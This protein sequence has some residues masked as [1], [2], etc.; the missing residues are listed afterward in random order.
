M[1][2]L[3]EPQTR[4]S[5]LSSQIPAAAPPTVARARWLDAMRGFTMIC[6]IS[7]GFGFPRLAGEAW[8][9]PIARQF[10]HV[11]WSG[12]TAWDLVQPFFM[13]IVGAAMPFAFA[14]RRAR[15][16]TWSNGWAHVLWRAFM[17]L[18][19]SQIAMIG[20]GST[21]GVQL[22]N[23]LAQIAFTYVIAYC[24]LDLPW[25]AQLLVAFGLLLAHYLMH[26]FWSGV[27]AGGMWARDANVGAA[28][29][30]AILGRNWSG[31]YA[32][33]NFVTS[34][35]ATIAGVMA[36]NV[37]RCA[38]TPTRRKFLILG[39]AAIGLI[40]LGLAI[41]PWIP[42]IKRIWTPT[43]AMVSVGCTLFALLAF[44]AIDLVWPRAPLGIF[45]AVGANCIFLYMTSILFAGRLHDIV[46]RLLG[47]LPEWLARRFHTAREPWLG[48]TADWLVLAILVGMAVWMH[49]RRILIKI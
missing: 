12:M 4:T 10:D 2:L 47:P 6:L 28:I 8:A 35:T 25:T 48:F 27:G 45:T 21:W 31:G 24:V 34:A 37:L 49:R 9:K 5:P 14:A 26:A 39:G 40:V 38:V 11:Q 13:F 22:I 32:T 29:D 42:L 30:R 23:V 46:I 19:L 33:L 36:A 41:S 16:G 1:T 17:L 7:R 44:Y 15:G 20:T 18:L 3:A 43:F